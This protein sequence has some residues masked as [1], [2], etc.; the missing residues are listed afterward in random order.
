MTFRTPCRSSRTKRTGSS[1]VRRFTWRKIPLAPLA[2]DRE[3]GLTKEP[4]P[5]S[6]CVSYVLPN[7]LRGHAVKRA[8]RETGALASAGARSST[9]SRIA[10]TTRDNCGAC[11]TTTRGKRANGRKLDIGRPYR[12]WPR[13]ITAC[14]YDLH[15]AL[16]ARP[17]P[18]C[19]CRTRQG[20]RLRRARV[21][22]FRRRG[23]A[24]RTWL[25][26]KRISE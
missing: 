11:T 16:P 3:K 10:V 17:S 1:T 6:R 12:R 19:T 21:T 2:R 13:R 20:A 14:A 24:C 8:Q 15:D 5:F 23:G 25:R 7:N 26:R 18:V 9:T 22:R 4:R